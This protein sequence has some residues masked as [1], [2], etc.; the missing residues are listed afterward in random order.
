M[1][2]RA[3]AL[4]S[5]CSVSVIIL[6]VTFPTVL[7]AGLL[8]AGKSAAAEDHGNTPLMMAARRGDAVRVRTLLDQGAVVNERN[9]LGVT[10]LMGAAGLP[11]S[12]PMRAEFPGSPEV[13]RLLL[14][15]GADVNARSATG[16]TALLAAVES[17][18]LESVKILTAAHANVNAV[19]DRG[20]SSLCAAA[21]AGFEDV[22]EE[23]LQH[24]AET[25]RGID[26]NGDS[27]LMLAIG[28]APSLSDTF[29][30]LRAL[31]ETRAFAKMA[32]ESVKESFGVPAASQGGTFERYFRIVTSLL[33][34]GADVNA[35]DRNGY[36]PLTLAA[37]T[38]HARF[39]RL[40]LDRGANV[41]ATARA[42]G[43]ST[44]LII[45]V[46]YPNFVMTK[47]ILE[48][49]PDVN[50]RDVFGKSALAYAIEADDQTI[51]GLLREAGAR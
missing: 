17:G 1:F 50:R 41:D 40:L 39:V 46:R 47:A 24:G 8:L 19:T 23:L 16:R 11:A 25:N 30:E 9:N 32:W 35:V 36:T 15:H 48:K 13:I 33:D 34:H 31:G 18:N 6:R 7:L 37:T 5:T 49:H 12:W 26:A 22:V 51:I 21:L 2:W 10:A 28:R 20:E 14:R 38:G 44:A 4:W 45:S 43:E 29:G 3:A 42:Y 27:A